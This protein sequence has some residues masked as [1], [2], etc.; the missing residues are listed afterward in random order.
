MKNLTQFLNESLDKD[1]KLISKW[2]DD[3][4]NIKSFAKDHDMDEDFVANI[5][6]WVQGCLEYHNDLEGVDG[7]L[8]FLGDDAADNFPEYAMDELD[9]DEDE[10]EKFDW[11]DV[12]ND[13][14]SLFE[15]LI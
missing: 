13:L 1:M 12:F 8:G 15:K 9:M 11:Y 6:A 7:L 14:V 2:L 10:L 3:Q 4:K 5:F